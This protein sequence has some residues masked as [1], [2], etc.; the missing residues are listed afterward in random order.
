MLTASNV[1][2]KHYLNHFSNV[3]KTKRSKAAHNNTIKRNSR[4]EKKVVSEIYESGDK[5]IFK[6]LGLQQT[7]VR[8]IISKWEKLKTVLK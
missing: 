4:L 1:E 5:A 2:Y 8:A 6:A 3:K 7:T